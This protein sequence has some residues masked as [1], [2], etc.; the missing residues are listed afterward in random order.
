MRGSAVPYHLP[1]ERVGPL[2]ENERRW[3]KGHDDFER[4]KAARAL[5]AD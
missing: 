2:L 1:H 3:G 4:E 5:K